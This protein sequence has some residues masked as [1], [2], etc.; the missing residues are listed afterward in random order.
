[1]KTTKTPLLGWGKFKD[2]GQEASLVLPG[3]D[4]F[5][6]RILSRKCLFLPKEFLNFSSVAIV[7]VAPMR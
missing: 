6:A 7:Y 2:T 3:R 5:S 4:P 1:M